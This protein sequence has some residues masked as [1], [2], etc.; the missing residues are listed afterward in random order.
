MS[1]TTNA[2]GLGGGGGSTASLLT[3]TK[4]GSTASTASR[5]KA[6]S[7]S[8]SVDMKTLNHANLPKAFSAPKRLTT[9]QSPSKKGEV[10]GVSVRKFPGDLSQARKGPPKGAVYAED[11]EREE[12]ELHA[13]YVQPTY[14]MSH[15]DLLRHRDFLKIDQSKLPLEI[16]D[17]V[18]FADKDLSPQQW[19]RSG[20][21]GKSPYFHNGVW[22]WHTVEV[23]GYDADT[24]E[25]M[26]KFVPDGIEKKVRRLN[27]QFD[28]ED[29]VIFKE[30]KR[31]A[32]EAREEAKRIIRLD[33]FIAQ[34]P[35][36]LVQPIR[37]ANVRRIHDKVVHGLAPSVPLP[38][39]GT[40]LGQLLH[41]LVGDMILF[42]ARTMR[43]AVLFA[44]MGG[45]Y[46]DVQTIAHYAELKLPPV[47]SRPP[48]PLNG[49]VP[50][51]SFPFDDRAIR[52]E[53][54]HYSSQPEV[55]GVF[56]WLH[57]RWTE[58]FQFY[59]F[60]DFCETVELPCAIKDFR[61]YQFEKSAATMKLLDKDLRRAFLDLLLDSVQDVYDFFQSNYN[62][63]R[64]GPLFKLF[65]VI[66]LKLAVFLRNIFRSSL[67][68]WEELVDRYTMV[69]PGVGHTPNGSVG[70][71]RR[72]SVVLSARR[73]S[74]ANKMTKKVSE[75]AALVIS[76]RSG[77]GDGGGSG[78]LTRGEDGLIT[79]SSEFPSLA[80][81]N[82]E[83]Y[84][85]LEIRTPLF[86]AE[87]A[88]NEGRLVLEPSVEDI[89]GA[90]IQS[91]DK[92]VASFR[93]ILSVDKE[94][95]SLLTLDARVIMNIGAGDPLYSDLDVAVKQMKTRINNKVTVTPFTPLPPGL[96][97]THASPPG[98]LPHPHTP[99]CH[100]P[101][102][103]PQ[104]GGGGDEGP[105]GPVQDVQRVRL[106]PRG[107]LGRLPRQLRHQLRQRRPVAHRLPRRIGQARAG[108]EADTAPVLPVRVV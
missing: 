45:V 87:L 78:G 74:T 95:M 35:K 6:S 4:N 23:L 86:Q 42:Y 67:T 63:Y 46:E 24:N 1:T 102:R 53:S 39:A 68:A 3:A 108:Q 85:P 69:R 93:S 94:A 5:L 18:E 21:G 19:I 54:Y 36:E 90:F 28:Q 84:F 17:N 11:L 62:A 80:L 32:E 2:N 107:G 47:P 37:Q 88:I 64:T 29:P 73:S 77:G 66:D 43:R 71:S 48:V 50:C 13:L 49:K 103:V 14:G 104:Q 52:I 99:H 65:R 92:M 7:S 51:P 105:A 58:K 89:Q 106:A 10:P 34:Q 81:R 70:V 83:V 72:P 57:D 75:V 15:E 79:G 98:P 30:R 96:S 26:I 27:L 76:E 60:V 20:S 91:I 22:M 8:S 100:E 55:L 9:Y 38:E 33:H 44:K 97:L 25:Y 40:A 101:L 59:S 16:F 82:T 12:Q 56:K 61:G 41:M 31:I